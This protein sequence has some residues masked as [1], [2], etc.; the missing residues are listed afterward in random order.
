MWSFRDGCVG[1]KMTKTNMIISVDGLESSVANRVRTY[2]KLLADQLSDRWLVS[3]DADDFNVK[4]IQEENQIEQALLNQDKHRIFVPLYKEY[5]PDEDFEFSIR[6]PLDSGK[7]IQTLNAIT[8]SRQLQPLTSDLDT[9][10]KKESTLKS[11]LSKFQAVNFFNKR[12]KIEKQP[13]QSNRKAFVSNLRKQL[14]SDANINEYKVVFLGSPGAGKT[15]AIN[16]VSEGRTL[17]TEVLPSDV[18]SAKKSQTTIGIDYG[19]MK[20][21]SDTKLRLFGNPGQMRYGFM[22]D[23]TARNAD[24]FIVLLDMSRKNPISEFEF[25]LN[26]LKKQ[27]IDAS[28]T[29]LCALTHCDLTQHNNVLITKLIKMKFGQTLKVFQLDARSE[30]QVNNLLDYTASC[31][32]KSRTEALPDYLQ[33]SLL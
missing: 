11:L 18:V 4:L 5:A 27:N 10:D 19:E 31:I 14:N 13:A 32:E 12:K 21:N 23:I 16:S 17:K 24:A 15:T 20:I 2:C 8:A 30:K 33:H 25:F 26:F 7:L 28:T 3:Q 9:S 22:W 6:R 1:D 29:V